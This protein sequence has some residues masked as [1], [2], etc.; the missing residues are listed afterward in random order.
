M[1][2]RYGKINSAKFILASSNYSVQR[3]LFSC[4]KRLFDFIINIGP[5]VKFCVSLVLV[6]V[7]KRAGFT[8]C[9]DFF[10]ITNRK[11]FLSNRWEKKT[12]FFR[13]CALT[14]N[15]SLRQLKCHLLTVY[16]NKK[17]KFHDLKPTVELNGITWVI[18]LLLLFH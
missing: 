2:W 9:R 8:P 18:I 4:P 10:R 6:F 3:R 13:S 12:S 16:M 7:R 14:E 5:W 17:V 1:R 11:H 15:F